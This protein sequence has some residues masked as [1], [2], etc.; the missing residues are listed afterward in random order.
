[1]KENSVVLSTGMPFKLQNS[2]DSAELS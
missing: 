1:L 2:F